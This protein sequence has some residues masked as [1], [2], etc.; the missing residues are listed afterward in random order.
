MLQPTRTKYRKA[1]KKGEYIKGNR[2]VK[3][4]WS[5]LLNFFEPERFNF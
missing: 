2:A 3:L 1:F 5:I 4:I